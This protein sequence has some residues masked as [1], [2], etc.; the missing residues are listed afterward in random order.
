[1]K[2]SSLLMA[3]LFMGVTLMVACVRPTSQPCPQ[4]DVLYQL[5]RCFVRQPDSVLHILDTLKTDVLSDKGRAQ[6]CLLKA[7]AYDALFRYDDEADSLLQEAR[8]YF[9]DGDDPYF[10]ART[11]EALSRFAF[12]RG[13]GEQLKLDW[14]LKAVTSIDRC[15]RLDERLARE[16]TPPETETDFIESYKHKLRMR[17]GMCYL[18]HYYTEEGLALLREVDRY[19][20]DHQEYKMRFNSAFMLGNAYFQQGEYDSCL[21]CFKN[22]LEAAQRNGNPEEIAYYH[23]SMAMYDVLRY[24]NGDFA[25]SLAGRN[26]L[27]QAISECHQGLALYEG[28]MFRYKEGLYA[29]LNKAFYRLEQYDSCV[30]YVN[31][32]MDFLNEHHFAIV[33]NNENAGLY[34]RLYKSYEALGDHAEALSYANKYFDMTQ[35]LEDQPKDFEKVKGDYEKRIEMMQLQSEQQA[36]RLRL[37]VLLVLAFA[38]IVLVLWLAYRYRK[39]KEIEALKFHETI[40][41]LQSELDQQSQQSLQALQQRAMALYHSGAPDALQR[42]LAEFATDYPHAMEKLA[43]TYPDL[44]GTERHIIV[45]SFLRFRVKEEADILGLSSHTVTKYRTKIRRKVGDDPIAELI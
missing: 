42:I 5:E 32:Q 13:E 9:V 23:F 21:N 43:A 20:A 8:D 25:D 28:P 40:H 38:T 3:S 37:Y 26:F 1:M 36:K 14:L 44:S 30:Y 33:P 45:L 27:T 7:S 41:Q 19:F 4:E 16:M 34:Y 31:K 2:T 22:G 18:D 35:A 39:E 12:K 29:Y 6:Y 24:D 15:C 17:L 10:E 11:C